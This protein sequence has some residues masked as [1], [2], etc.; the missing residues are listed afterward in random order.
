M[1]FHPYQIGRMA[2]I[3]GQ[4]KH[5]IKDQVGNT[6]L[7]GNG[8]IERTVARL[9]DRDRPDLAER[10]ETGELSANAAAIEA[11][12]SGNARRHGSEPDIR[13]EAVTAGVGRPAKTNGDNIT[14]TRP[15]R[16]ASMAPITISASNT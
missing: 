3:A 4:N 6:H 7:K 8:S 12:S 13:R 16:G 15:E 10:V 2:G 14:I 1:S 5:V 11:G 9:R